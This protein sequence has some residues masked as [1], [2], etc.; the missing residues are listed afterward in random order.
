MR[1]F[2]AI[3][4]TVL[5]LWMGGRY[6]YFVIRKQVRPTLTT[7]LIFE[8][9]IVLSLASYFSSKQPD[10]VSNI[11][12]VVDFV[13]VLMIILAITIFGKPGAWKFESYEQACLWIAGVGLVIWAVSGR[14]FISNLA[15]QSVMVV[16]YG[17][18]WKKLRHAKENPESLGCWTIACVAASLAFVTGYL[19]ADKW[20]MIYTARATACTLITIVLI[21]RVKRR[22]AAYTGGT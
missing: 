14:P 6:S 2:C 1:E 20:G 11:A 7:W 22:S 3:A 18:L 9:G 13:D 12:N 8:T 17:P 4:A 16:A 21:I 19:S 5:T 10:P 15:F